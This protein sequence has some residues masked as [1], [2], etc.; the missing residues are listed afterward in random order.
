MAQYIVELNGD[1]ALTGRCIMAVLLGFTVS[2][3]GSSGHVRSHEATVAAAGTLVHKGEP[4]A[5]YQVVLTP[6]NGTAAV[7]TTDAEGK[8]SLG[9]NRPG[10]GAIAGEHSV[11]VI[12]VGPPDGAYDG[13]NDFSPPPPPKVKL[14]A[15]YGNAATS[16]IKVTIPAGGNQDFKIELP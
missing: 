11:A 4:L 6:A 8:F 14:P 3:C 10:D 1:R 5:H 9:T 13:I 7:G 15:K 2:G 12:Y 16:G